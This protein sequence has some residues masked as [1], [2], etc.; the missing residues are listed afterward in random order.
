M[1]KCIACSKMDAF[2]DGYT[3]A[4]EYGIFQDGGYRLKQ[5]AE[6][7]GRFDGGFPASSVGQ[8]LKKCCC[9]MPFSL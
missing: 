8:A 7:K 9:I 3:K 2:F 6:C 1:Y 5:T 4:L